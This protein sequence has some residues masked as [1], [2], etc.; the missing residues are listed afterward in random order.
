MQA[1]HIVETIVARDGWTPDLAQIAGDLRRSI[2][3]LDGA[4]TA[5]RLIP[6]PDSARLR[7]LAQT[8]IA[9]GRWSDAVDSLARLT[10]AAPDDRWAQLNYGLLMSSVDPHAAMSALQSAAE[11]D[12]YGP[13]ANIVFDALDRNLDQP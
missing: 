4:V 8:Q 3:D 9:L 10:E 13:L 5:W 6:S 12:A 7:S 11:D 1:L 2:G